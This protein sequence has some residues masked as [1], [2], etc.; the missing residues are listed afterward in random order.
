[1]T[2]RG[3]SIVRLDP[4]FDAELQYQDGAEALVPAEGREGQLV[5]SGDGVVTGTRIAGRLRWTLFEGPGELLCAMAPVARIETADGA[6]IRFEARGYG[7]RPTATDR[8]WSVAAALRFDT[9]DVRYRWLTQLVGVWEGEFDADTGRA[10]YRAFLPTFD[11]DAA[12]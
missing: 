1:M 8:I 6:E 10:R 9:E 7:R 2:T 3:K 11:S 12:Q 5:G 4:L